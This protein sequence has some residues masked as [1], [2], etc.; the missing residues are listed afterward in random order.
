M[1]KDNEK[2]SFWKSITG[3][4]TIIS[5]IIAI[6][7]GLIAIFSPTPPVVNLFKASPDEITAGESFTLS[8]SVSDATKIIISPEIGTVEL[9][10]LKMLSPNETTTYT[11]TAT[12]NDGKDVGSITV[13]VRKKPEINFFKA[14]QDKINTGETSTLSWSVSD[15][16]SVTIFPGIGEVGLIGTETVSPVKNTIYALT[17]TNEAGSIYDEV[18]VNLNENTVILE[19]IP[20]ET[21]HSRTNYLGYPGDKTGPEL[22]V[23]YR[24]EEW[25]Q[26]Y[27]SFETSKIPPGSTIKD[28]I[29]DFNVSEMERY[30]FYNIGTL[31]VYPVQYDYIPNYYESTT[32]KIASFSS[33]DDLKSMK[34]NRDVA[35]NLQ[36]KLEYPRFQ[37]R[38]QFKQ[39]A[40]PEDKYN[41]LEFDFI[42]LI[43]TYTPP[44]Y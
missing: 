3:V 5:T 4:I 40:T 14:S 21:G 12:N 43:V 13:K 6:T 27:L 39:V 33:L 42:N 28:V 19:T 30:P 38:L 9:A 18:Q 20:S 7:A 25:Y 36:E 15:A 11:I 8:W 31:D 10:G 22:T 23:G 26:I 16:I 34:S 35:A 37:L 1:P 41:W 29:F 32:G 17:A 44:N 24:S 2:K